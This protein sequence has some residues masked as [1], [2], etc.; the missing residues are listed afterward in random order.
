VLGHVVDANGLERSVTNV[1][2]DFR[3]RGNLRKHFRREM[4]TGRR[5]RDRAALFGINSLVS[6]T[7]F[8]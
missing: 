7:I 3:D 4:Q 6:F 2:G 1:Q 5:R 8:V